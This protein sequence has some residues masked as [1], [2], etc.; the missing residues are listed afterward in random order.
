MPRPKL[1]NGGRARPATHQIIVGIGPVTAKRARHASANEGAGRGAKVVERWRGQGV[2]VRGGC[3][4]LWAARRLTVREEDQQQVARLLGQLVQAVHLATLKHR[5]RREAGL[6]VGRLGGDDLR[7]G[8]GWARVGLGA[9]S[10]E[11]AMAEEAPGTQRKGSS[12]RARGGV[13]C[14]SAA[15]RT[16]ARPRRSRARPCTRGSPR[17]GGGLRRAVRA[18]AEERTC[19][20]IWRS[21]PVRAFFASPSPWPCSSAPCACPL[22]ARGDAGFALAPADAALDSDMVRGGRERLPFWFVRTRK[23]RS[24]RGA[25][26]RSRRGLAGRRTSQAKI[27]KVKGSLRR[28]FPTNPG[29]LSRRMPGWS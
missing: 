27:G 24:R 22:A 8:R 6:V 9:G 19:S 17:A 10:A 26:E 29:F 18:L 1:T 15:R 14:A 13:L 23:G 7:R 25:Q 5:L 11:R 12:A 3:A 20:S 28:E 21:T 16:V 4:G 2:C